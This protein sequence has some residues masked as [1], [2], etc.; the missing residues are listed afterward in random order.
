LGV[1]AVSTCQFQKMPTAVA[2]M[3]RGVHQDSRFGAGVSEVE[4]IVV[5]FCGLIDALHGDS[6]NVNVR[7]VMSWV[8]KEIHGNNDAIEHRNNGHKVSF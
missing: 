6:S 3:I 8:V 5:D 4:S 7:H 2:Q 1:W